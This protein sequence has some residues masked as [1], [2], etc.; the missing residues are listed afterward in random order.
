MRTVNC[1]ALPGSLLES[2][3]FGHERGAF[4]GAERD[5]EGVFAAADR[6]S[7]FLDEVGELSSAAQAALL[8]VLQE[9]RFVP[10]GGTE[11]VAVDVRVI[12]ATHR[13][14]EA[15]VEAGQFRQDLLFRLNAVTLE[16]PPLRDRPAELLPLAQRFLGPGAPRLGEQAAQGLRR[17]SWPGNVRELR[18]AMERAAVLARGDEILPGDLPDGLRAGGAPPTAAAAP[19]DSEETLKEQVRRFEAELVLDAL[20]ACGWRRK[21]AAARLGLPLRTLAHRMK[22]LGIKRA[23]YSVS[24]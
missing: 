24:D 23:G 8:R 7:V 15:M 3:L 12:A 6:G 5:R 19:P 1:G 14:L 21:E 2:T 9:G 20:R 13:D 18:N 11:E 16:V 10:V 4:T 17:H 22:V